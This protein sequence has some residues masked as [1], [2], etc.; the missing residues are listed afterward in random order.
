MVSAVD[1]SSTAP[2]NDDRGDDK[3]YVRSW[4][5][6][7]VKDAPLIAVVERAGLC[8]VLHDDLAVHLLVARTAEVIAKKIVDAGLLGRKV[9]S[10]NLAGRA[11]GP[12]ES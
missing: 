5:V 3:C 6:A 7:C 10:G 2:T 1:A 11:G 4:P 9:Y 8:L 12:H